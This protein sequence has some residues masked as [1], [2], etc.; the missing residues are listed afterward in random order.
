[1]QFITREQ[2]EWNLDGGRFCLER[3]SDED[4][5]LLAPDG[6]VLELSLGEWVSLRD[7]LEH[8]L[9]RGSRKGRKRRERPRRS[10]QPWSDDEDQRLGEM[11]AR[12]GEMRA[13]AAVFERSEG[14]IKARLAH[15]GLVEDGGRFAV[16]RPAAG[17][18]GGSE[19][20]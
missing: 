4:M 17:A 1:M 11:F 20:E 10:G 3:R 12:G 2:I 9:G 6:Q 13:L 14:S 18:E 8:V 7:G 5:C 15:L 16:R 19:E